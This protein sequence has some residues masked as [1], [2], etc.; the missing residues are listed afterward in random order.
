MSDRKARTKGRGRRRKGKGRSTRGYTTASAKAIFRVAHG[1]AMSPIYFAS[2]FPFGLLNSGTTGVIA[3]STTSV[4]SPSISLFSEYSALTG[5]Y[6]EIR[7]VAARVT[8]VPK[9]QTTG[10]TSTLQDLMYIGTRPDYSLNSPP[11]VPTGPQFVENL[12]NPMTISTYGVRPFVYNMYVAQDLDFAAVS[13]D[14]PTPSTPY[15]G[16][17]GVV[18]YYAANLATNSVN[19]FDINIRC[20]WQIRGRV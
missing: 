7:L 3:S 13:N 18:M 6:S 17:P 10:S 19:Y 11:P 16:S 4:L 5:L 8:L 2:T 15:A 12:Q 1:R 20:I 9:T 14:A